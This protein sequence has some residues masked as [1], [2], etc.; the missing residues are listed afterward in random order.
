MKTAIKI[1]SLAFS[2]MLPLF[3]RAQVNYGLTTNGVVITAY[4]AS[5]PNASGNIVI[6]TYEGYPVTSI[7]D[8]AF[9]R[10]N[11]TGVT[12]DNSVTNMGNYTFYNCYSLTSVT[13]GTGVT[14]IGNYTFNGCYDLASLTLG[15]NVITMGE[16]A[17][18]GCYSL[19]SV[20]IPD[21]VTS[22]GYYAFYTDGMTNV[23]IGNG[24]TNLG[25]GVFGSCNNLTNIAVA[26]SNPAYSSTNGVLFDKPQTTLIQFPA[27]L[28]GSYTIPNTVA[29]LADHAFASCIGLTNVTMPNSLII[30]GTN[31]FNDCNSLTNVTIG[32]SVSNIEYEAFSGCSS[33]ARI[34]MPNSVTNIGADAFYGCSSLASVTIPNSVISIGD[35]AFIFSGLTNVT[36]GSGVANVGKGAFSDCYSLTQAYFLGNA[37]LV[38]GTLGSSDSSVFSSSG[39]ESGTVYYYAVAGGWGS[40]FGGWPT[41]E[42][43]AP[44]QIYG[45][46]IRT[47]SFNFTITGV[48]NQVVTIQASTNLMSWQTIWTNTLST[49]ST[50]FTDAQ[51]RNYPYRF[52]RAY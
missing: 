26:A 42:L 15:T 19:G 3:A 32:N 39:T 33:L 31:A 2:L 37:P 17:F 51:W 27:G 29:S 18:Y 23:T 6:D 48:S 45:A 16:Y 50:N 46:S 1:L 24:L 38:D 12:I 21:S 11:L 20:T 4:V 7:Q 36:V 13:I 5:S 41:L 40:T 49:T 10:C 30:V 35:Y 22:I 28:A 14:S 44:P 25:I 47:N 43:P 34:M 52:Y 8:F 9:I